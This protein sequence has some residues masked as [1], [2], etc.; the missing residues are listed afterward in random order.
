MDGLRVETWRGRETRPLVRD[1]TLDLHEGEVLALVGA[2]GSG[3]SLACAGLLGVLPPGTRQA[4]GRI[5]LGGTEAKPE[6]LRG[7]AVASVLQAPRTAF[8]P[9]RTLRDHA[10]ETLAVAGIRGRAGR[11]AMNEALAA[12]GLGEDPGVPDLYPFQMSGGMLQ[13]AMIALALLS[14]APFLVADEPTTDLDL[15]AQA[16]I[17]DLLARLVRKHDL[18]LLIVTHDLG[19]VA[20]LAD[21]VA[22]MEEGRIVETGDVSR[23]FAE[24]A[25]PATRAL[26]D[27]H[28]AL[29]EVQA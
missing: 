19:V 26:L 5:L 16:G 18:G 8:N 1:V 29:H 9:L 2:S 4:G 3:K 22:V 10:G 6:A 14:R 25:H 11:E 12:V 21:R 24:P 17:L 23:L 15:V 28:R 7:R 27:A 13:R 20:R